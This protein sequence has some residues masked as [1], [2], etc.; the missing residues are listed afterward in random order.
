MPEDDQ[1]G[2]NTLPG[3][4]DALGENLNHIKP[5]SNRQSIRTE[6]NA[7]TLSQ[8]REQLKKLEDD[9]DLTAASDFF[10]AQWWESKNTQ[11]GLSTVVVSGIVTVLG[12]IAPVGSPSPED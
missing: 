3:N 11:L 10:M 8:I 4:R 7:A 5:L 2:V 9:T 1:L 6:T 12:A